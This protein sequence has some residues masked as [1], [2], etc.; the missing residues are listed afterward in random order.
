[1]AKTEEE[2]VILIH[3]ESGV[4]FAFAPYLAAFTLEQGKGRERWWTK[5]EKGKQNANKRRSTKAKA[6]TTQ[7][8]EDDC[9]CN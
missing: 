7:A 4:E 6:A 3:P 5:K 2:K 1:M 8:P 9:G